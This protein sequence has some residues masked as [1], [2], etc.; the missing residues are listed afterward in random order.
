[1]VTQKACPV[2][3]VKF[4]YYIEKNISKYKCLEVII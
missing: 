4:A 2:L 3:G 1:L